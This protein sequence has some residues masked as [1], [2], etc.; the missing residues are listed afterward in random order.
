MQQDEFWLLLMPLW[1]T[2]LIDNREA[3]SLNFYK[4]Q[5][6]THLFTQH[7]T[8]WLSRNLS[9]IGLTSA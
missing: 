7:L 8:S 5:I 4:R 3:A 6:K 2:L 1:D 9:A